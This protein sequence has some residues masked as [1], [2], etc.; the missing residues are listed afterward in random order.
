MEVRHGYMHVPDAP[1]L[2]VA[3]DEEAIARYTVEEGY[4]PP[5]PRNLYRVVWPS[6]ASVTYAVGKHGTRTA[7]PVPERGVW[8]DFSVGN[9][10]LFHRGV[11]MEILADDGSAKWEALNRRAQMAPV[12]E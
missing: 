9:Q 11:R 2:G 12:R 5:P 8:D 3:P 10:P 6:G 1:G 4:D 7:H